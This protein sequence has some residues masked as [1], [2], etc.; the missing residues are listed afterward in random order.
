MI[1]PFC[2]IIKGKSPS[3]TLYEDK[4]VKV[5]LDIKPA[6][7]GHS[8]IL[9]KKHRNDIF[10][11]SKAD[12]Q[13]VARVTKKLADYWKS[14]NLVKDVNIIHSAGRF[15][16]QEVSHF[17]LHIIPR[18]KGDGVNFRYKTKNTIVR[19]L[20][21]TRAKFSLSDKSDVYKP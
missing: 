2:A 6:T 15:A 8:L 4:I 18:T 21:K 13:H 11:I 10:D 14:R 20:P 5:I 17:H 9:L 16:Q 7:E 1:C 3:H 19:R 12:F